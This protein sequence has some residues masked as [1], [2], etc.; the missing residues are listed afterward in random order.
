M[1]SDVAARAARTD[2]EARAAGATTLVHLGELSAAARA[3]V[4]EPLAPA[5]PDTLRKL[6]DPANRPQ[7]P[8][9]PP[10]PAL[11]DLRL[12]E[13][14][15]L[16]LQP[17]LTCLRNARQGTAA[18]PSGRTNEPP[19]SSWPSSRSLQANGRDAASSSE[20]PLRRTHPC[21][22]VRIRAP[23]SLHAV[24]VWPQHP[25]R[26]RDTCPSPACCH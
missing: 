25:G 11:V 13:E 18:G 16:P 26:H 5:F 15:A 19:H 3:L 24:S 6:C 4:I 14:G 7:T 20:T 12:A 8:Y 17:F 21:T 1:R 22:G 9:A 23:S 10:D 2:D